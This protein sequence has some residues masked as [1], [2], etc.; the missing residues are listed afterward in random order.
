M[1]RPGGIYA[2]LY[3]MI[4]GILVVVSAAM[5]AIGARGMSSAT[6]EP[7]SLLYI[8]LGASGLAFTVYSF[9][10]VQSRLRALRVEIARV[11][12]TFEC[13]SCHEKASRSFREGDYVFGPGDK[14]AKCGHEKTTVVSIYAERPQLRRESAG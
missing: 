4:L 14:C 6:E 5:L 2:S 12:T 1:E 10:R 8:G 9:Q 11:I 13:D 3:F 7:L